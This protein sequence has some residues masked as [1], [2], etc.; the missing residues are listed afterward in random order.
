MNP[1]AAFSLVTAP[2]V[3]RPVETKAR[4][5]YIQSDTGGY[6]H[7][8]VTELVEVGSMEYPCRVVVFQQRGLFPVFDSWTDENGVFKVEYLSMSEE[9]MAMAFDHSG[10]YDP[11]AIWRI[12]PNLMDPSREPVEYPWD[13]SMVAGIASWMDP[14]EGVEMVNDTY[15]KSWTSRVTGLKYESPNPT[16]Y[17]EFGDVGGNMAA[18]F[19]LDYRYMRNLNSAEVSAAYGNKPSFWTLFVGSRR[20]DDQGWMPMH[21]F[22]QTG[23][24][25]AMTFFL[26]IDVAANRA[27]LNI[28]NPGGNEFA[29][30]TEPY[31]NDP[32]VIWMS[33]EGGTISSQVNGG[34]FNVSTGGNPANTF[35]VLKGAV[36]G[37]NRGE[38][39]FADSDVF[40]LISGAG[41]APSRADAD[42]LVGWAAHKYGLVDKLPA[43]HPWKNRAPVLII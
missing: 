42:R 3:W 11:V 35:S 17:V 9:Y 31:N 43:D 30:Q 16:H 21:S 5:T 39:M 36:I 7:G 6:I 15:A 14:T 24:E 40:C 25:N 18:K 10:R 27:S 2:N 32:A 12:K 4:G 22:G 34:V 29:R 28:T 26:G 20:R 38:Y 13:P 23:G 1:V 19:R 33:W 37:A 41:P 8:D